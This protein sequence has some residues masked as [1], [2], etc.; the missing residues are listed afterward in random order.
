MTG[1]SVQ[2]V[3]PAKVNLYLAV[4]ARRSD[5][6]H[7]VETVLAAL[8]LV[9]TVT[10][11]EADDLS[12]E[13]SRDLGIPAAENLVV[14]A[15]E[16]LAAQAGRQPHVAITLDKQIPHGAGL[17][18]GSS[19]AAAAIA[20]LAQLWDLD[21]PQ[22]ALVEVAASLGADVPFFLRGGVALFD[23][24]GDQFVRQLPFVP[25][26]IVLVRPDEL[27][28]TGAA[29]AGF[30]RIMQP[31]APGS[32]GLITALNGGIPAGI[33]A[34]LYNNMT[35]ASCGLVGSVAEALAW[36]SGATGVV[37]AAMA[38][39]G[40]AVF[41]VCESAYHAQ[42]CATQAQSKGW[43]SSAA[44]TVAEGVRPQLIGG[45]A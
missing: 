17:G 10:L 24:R 23:G 35:E 11:S 9:D 41:G 39:S 30:D 32:A 37:G 15:V 45:G 19:D 27:V 42:E 36:V 1:R 5:G 26:D 12:F 29:Y 8:D 43:W 16:A 7:D 3:A 38:G 20:G 44:Q 33:A 21:L 14:K 22:E 34:A 28:P 2:V 13:C 25:L 6:Y 4:G 18:G 31:G 40:S